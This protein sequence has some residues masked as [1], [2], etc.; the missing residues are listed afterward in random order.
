MTLVHGVDLV[1]VSRIESMLEKHGDQ[2]LQR[3]YTPVERRDSDAGGAR[4]AEHYAARFAA[5]EAVFKALGTGWSGG[6]GWQDVGVERLPGGQPI[7]CIEG[8]AARVARDKG[9]DVWAISLSHTGTHAM[10][11]VV[12]SEGR[13]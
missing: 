13:P 5:K 2:F 10:A 12:G 4:R 8:E 11:S 1:E 6:V 7:V 3:V 9:I